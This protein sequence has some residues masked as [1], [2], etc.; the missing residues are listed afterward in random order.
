LKTFSNDIF[1][2]SMSIPVCENE[3]N[4]FIGEAAQYAVTLLFSVSSLSA[5]Y[6][7]FIDE[8]DS[9]NQDEIGADELFEAFTYLQDQLKF[10]DVSKSVKFDYTKRPLTI[11]G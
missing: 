5:I 8:R 4:N 1:I 11:I 3:L 7:L 10:K 6:R 2:K 9:I